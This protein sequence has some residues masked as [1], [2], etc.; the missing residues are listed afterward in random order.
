MIVDELMIVII[1][2]KDD[3]QNPIKPLKQIIGQFNNIEN[4]S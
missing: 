3:Q 1:T 4:N 2:F